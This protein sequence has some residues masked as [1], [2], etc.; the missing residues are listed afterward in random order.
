MEPLELPW[1]ITLPEEAKCV[2]EELSAGCKYKGRV[3]E[4]QDACVEGGEVFCVEGGEVFCELEL[5]WIPSFDA[6]PSHKI[7]LTLGNS[8]MYK[9]S[10]NDGPVFMVLYVHVCDLGCC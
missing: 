5:K 3:C 2:P 1:L 10:L 7:T 8:R 9:K 4:P 6:L